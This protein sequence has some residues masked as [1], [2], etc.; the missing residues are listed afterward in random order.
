MPLQFFYPPVT[1]ELLSEVVHRIVKV[2]RPQKIILFGSRARGDARPD[3][4]LDLLIVERSALPRHKRAVR[5]LE[6]LTGLLPGKDVVVWSP[7]EIAQWEGIP[8]SFI[9]T[10]LRE[11]KTL[12]AR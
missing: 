9:M 7:D 11:G 2:G 3:S 10:A 6:A 4:D 1:D 5:Y 8:S 12:Y